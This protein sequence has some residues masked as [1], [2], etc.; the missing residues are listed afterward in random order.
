[1]SL[2]SY[3]AQMDSQIPSPHEKKTNRNFPKFD[4]ATHQKMGVTEHMHLS[5]GTWFCHAISL[6]DACL[7]PHSKRVTAFKYQ[8]LL[9]LLLQSRATVPLPAI[10][11]VDVPVVAAEAKVPSRERNEQQAL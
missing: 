6:Y 5:F 4:V 8:L 9:G 10:G 3:R 2:L 1:M 11:V 7:R